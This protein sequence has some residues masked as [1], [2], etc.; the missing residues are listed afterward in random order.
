M[1]NFAA[2]IDGRAKGFQCNFD[3]VDCTNDT[4]AKPT[5][6]KQKNPLLT[7]GSF[8]LD[9][10][11][12]GIKRGYSHLTIIPISERSM[13]VREYPDPHSPS[14]MLLC[15]PVDFL[16]DRRQFLIGSF[17]FFQGLLQEFCRLG[18]SEDLGVSSNR[19]ICRHLVMLH[20]LGR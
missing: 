16:R 6:F 18:L 3:D 15:L 9:A 14:G 10:V 7:R 20:T 2:D 8:T 1:D 17:F 4:G 13:R 5:R 19:S 11:W 12:D